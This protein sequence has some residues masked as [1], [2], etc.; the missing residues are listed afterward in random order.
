MKT[1]HCL[2][3]G[4]ILFIHFSVSNLVPINRIYVL[5][6]C[7]CLVYQN[8]SNFCCISCLFL[9]RNTTPRGGTLQR[10]CLLLQAFSATPSSWWKLCAYAGFL[11]SSSCDSQALPARSTSLRMSWTSLISAPSFLTLSPWEQSWPKTM[12]R[13]R[14]HPWPSSESSGWWGSSESSSCL[15]IPKAFRSSVRRYGQACVSLACSSSSCLLGSSSSP[16]P[17]T[18]RKLTT[19]PR[20][21]SAYRMAFG[22]QL[23]QWPQWDTVTCTLRLFGVK[24]LAPCA[25]LLVFWPSLCL[26]P[27]LCPTSATSTTERLNVKIIPSTI[28]CR[29]PCGRMRSLKER[30]LRMGIGIKIQNFIPLKESA[31]LSTGLYLADYVLDRWQST[32]E[33]TCIWENH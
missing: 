24:W 16:A 19:T 25:P 7:T 33:V 21:L 1:L 14:P 23:S 15:G 13:L 20:I 17:S 32:Q 8:V 29:H 6:L 4:A 3:S 31:T 5:L 28:M 18:L 30:R 26:C 9:F 12:T 27:S 10:T 22:G 2:I 11:L